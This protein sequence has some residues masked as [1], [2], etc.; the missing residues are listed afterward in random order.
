MAEVSFRSIGGNALP[1]FLSI[2][3]KGKQNHEMRCIF[4]N[5]A[6][7]VGDTIYSPYGQGV[8]AVKFSVVEITESRKARGDWSGESYKGKTPTY[9]SLLLA[10]VVEEKLSTKE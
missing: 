5:G 7:D 4:D 9:Y 8:D 1:S 3:P 6:I 2:E 10:V